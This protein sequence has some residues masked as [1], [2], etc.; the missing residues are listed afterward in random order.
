LSTNNDEEPIVIPKVTIKTID[1]EVST[2]K[3][4]IKPIPKPIELCPTLAQPLEIV[5]STKVVESGQDSPRIILKINKGSSTTTTE[6]TPK[7]LH[8][9]VVTVIEDSNDEPKAPARQKNDLKRAH[10]EVVDEIPSPVEA[11]KAKTQPQ[12][13]ADDDVIMVN[14][15]PVQ[16]QSQK[17]PIKVQET[18]SNFKEILRMTRQKQQQ[19]AAQE[20][21]VDA[22]KNGK[23]D[24]LTSRLMAE[25][26]T[27][28][29][30]DC[31]IIDEPVVV[32]E[33]LDTF[34]IAKH[35][36]RLSEEQRPESPPPVVVK[37]RG[38]PKKLVTPIVIPDERSR[39]EDE[40]SQ[41]DCQTDPLALPPTIEEQMD[42]DSN[43]NNT[44]GEEAEDSETID[45]KGTPR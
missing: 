11:K 19:L 41:A 38:R 34:S 37:R 28:S 1:D 2:P 23:H 20:A 25:N 30:S 31:V 14:S 10:S 7:K 24:K 12:K 22:N 32:V 45:S 17:E 35:K 9:P 29:S 16:E 4:T 33:K 3:V 26:D 15:E 42:E 21:V 43:Q 18:Q 36:K 8:S 40:D 6:T 27:G 44:G 13:E 39:T 5:T